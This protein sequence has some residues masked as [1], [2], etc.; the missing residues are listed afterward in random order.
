ML[1]E[2]VENQILRRKLLV[3]AI[4]LVLV[5][6]LRIRI[7]RIKE[8][9]D[10]DR[11]LFNVLIRLFILRVNRRLFREVLLRLVYIGLVD[12]LVKLLVELLELGVDDVDELLVITLIPKIF[13]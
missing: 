2:D 7:N 8:L 11:V 10:F 13:S 12:L 6:I 9:V 4:D 5:F 3:D 1:L